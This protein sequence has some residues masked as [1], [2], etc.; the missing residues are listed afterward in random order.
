MS[1]TSFVF[2]SFLMIACAR[3]GHGDSENKLF[4]D[5]VRA[6]AAED[7]DSAIRF[8]E[9]SAKKSHSANLYGNL[10]NLY[11]K[12][13]M[14]GR[15]ILNY[16]KALLLAP[17][18]RDLAANLSF[19]REIAR[20]QSSSLDNQSGYFDFSPSSMDAWTIFTAIIFWGGLGGMGL[21]FF[22]QVDRIFQVI[23]F[24][25][26]I[27]LT[28]LGVGAVTKAKGNH[29][30]QNREI[31]AIASSASEDSNGSKVIYLRVSAFEESAANTSVVPGE[32]LFLEIKENQPAKD[33]SFKKHTNAI[34]EVWYFVRS[35]EGRNKG[36]IRQDQL[37]RI[38]ASKDS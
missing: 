37:E 36:W 12:K 21:I 14:F 3:S 17:D 6:E 5:A 2:A 24:L 1:R 35:L 32:S 29:D 4:Y 34:G 23:V 9:Q 31:V 7:F 30:L 13:E 25:F 22:L 26:W 16:R 8:Y 28:S 15:S 19:V 38:I 27:A 20:I 18:N 10:A 33:G 11:F